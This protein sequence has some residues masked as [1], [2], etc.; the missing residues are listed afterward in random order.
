MINSYY[1]PRNKA[2]ADGAISFYLDHYVSV[3]ISR[4]TYGI[5]FHTAY[6]PSDPEHVCRSATKYISAD[7]KTLVQNAFDVILPKVG[8][9]IMWDTPLFYAYYQRRGLYRMSECLRLKNFGDRIVM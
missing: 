4:I 1:K 5:E 8:L 7:G 6:N 3:R 9:I 2:V